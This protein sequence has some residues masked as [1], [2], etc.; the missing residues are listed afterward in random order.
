M[1]QK[2][3]STIPE[4]TQPGL[5]RC[6]LDTS[7]GRKNVQDLV[8]EEIAV[9]MVYNGIS[10]AVMMATPIDLEDFAYGFSLTEGIIDSVEQLRSIELEESDLGWQVKMDIASS[11]FMQLK[12]R[13]R[14][15]SGRTGC[16]LCGMESLEAVMPDLPPVPAANLPRPA[17]IKKALTN[18]EA[19]QVLRYLCGGVHAAALVN[20]EGEIV[21]LREDVGRHNALDKILG[22]MAR[23][24]I[25]YNSDYFILASSRASYEMV[26]KIASRSLSNLVA[27]SAPTTLAIDLAA[28]AGINLIGF[29]RPAKQNI[30]HAQQG[31]L[32]KL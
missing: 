31:R 1:S 8:A 29:A 11:A 28:K 25:P 24:A 26:A 13:R 27:V 10:H 4:E 21:L 7:D 15:L 12:Q 14:Q 19:G 6:D 32:S 9:A 30:Y 2:P 22:H 16:G 3:S 20:T 23:A 5:R 17:V 18:F